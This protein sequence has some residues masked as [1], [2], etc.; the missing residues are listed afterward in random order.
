MVELGQRP[1]QVR[2]PG[3]AHEAAAVLEAGALREQHAELGARAAHAGAQR[4]AER[5]GRWHAFR[6]LTEMGSY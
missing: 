4:A 5:L 2:G 3:G 1:Q 6:T